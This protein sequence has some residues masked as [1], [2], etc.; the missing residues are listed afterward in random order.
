MSKYYIK[1]KN[2]TLLSFFM[3]QNIGLEISKIE[4]I[5]KN[6]QIYPP[7]LQDEVNEDTIISFINSRIIPKNRA[8]VEDILRSYNLTLN[9]KKGVIDVSKGLSLT[10]DYWIVQDQSLD[11]DKYNL[12]DNEFS[13]VLFNS[14]LVLL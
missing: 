11:F 8:F 2:I 13:D 12:F 4:I 7:Q 9:D 6:T 5:N 14:C 3:G 1:L 10:D